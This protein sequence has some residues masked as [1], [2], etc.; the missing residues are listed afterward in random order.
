MITKRNWSRRADLA[1]FERGP[2]YWRGGLRFFVFDG[3]DYVAELVDSPQEI[4]KFLIANG[5]FWINL[6]HQLRDD[7]SP[8]LV[9][10]FHKVSNC[11]AFTSIILEL[12]NS[13]FDQFADIWMFL[14]ESLKK[15]R[16]RIRSG[17]IM[18]WLPSFSW[19]CFM[20]EKNVL[21][22]GFSEMC[23]DVAS[24]ARGG[25]FNCHLILSDT[26]RTPMT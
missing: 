23:E 15:N 8:I 3:G 6:D 25:H 22:I 2:N 10:I 21:L 4:F 5:A 14:L 7:I 24:L 12:L 18:M 17:T 26:T 19:P 16:I 1:F 13:F 9:S 11:H 20:S